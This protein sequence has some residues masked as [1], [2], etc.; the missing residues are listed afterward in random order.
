MPGWQ[1]TA[2]TIICDA[3][4]EEV[5]VT[6]FGDGRASCTG[7]SRRTDKADGSPA[8]SCSADDCSQITAY[9]A[10]LEAEEEQLG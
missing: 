10:R 1:L 8:P 9:K 6:I 3:C 5:T 7:T 4:G 2:T